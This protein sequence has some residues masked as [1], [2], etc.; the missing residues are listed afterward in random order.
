MVD[1][2]TSSEDVIEFQDKEAGVIKGKVAMWRYN[3]M[4]NWV[5]TTVT[6]KCFDKKIELTLNTIVEGG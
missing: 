2:F 5:M 3:E 4:H 1:L 6:V